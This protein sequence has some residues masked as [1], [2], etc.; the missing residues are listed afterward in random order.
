MSKILIVD[1]EKNV[2]RILKDYLTNEGFEVIEG[3]DGENGIDQLMKHT[4]VDLVLLDVRMPRLSG[5]EAIEEMKTISDVP[6]I[7][8]TALDESFDEVKGLELGADDYITKPFSYNVLV[9]RVKSTL[10]KNNRFKTTTLEVDGLLIDFTNKRVLLEGEDVELTLKEF[11]VL[12][13]L[14]KN[15]N[16]NME[17]GLILDRVWGYDY[18][19]DP[20]TVDT[21]VKTLRAKL[22][23]SGKIIK[24]ARGV[25]YRFE[26]V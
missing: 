25:G 22:G 11:Q 20:R 17:R 8:L 2:R 13:L 15:K 26:T 16:I 5:F 9:A 1:D 12:E 18:Y 4:D 6:V 24:T 14:I 10:K 23:E 3:V 19:G 21:H 7:F